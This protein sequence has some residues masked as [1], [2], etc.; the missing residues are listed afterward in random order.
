MESQ[1]VR[2]STERV[3]EPN[4][5][6]S[7]TLQQ[8]QP[9]AAQ[10]VSTRESSMSRTSL[11][12]LLNRLPKPAQELVLT[13]YQGMSVWTYLRTRRDLDALLRANLDDTEGLKARL[14]ELQK[15]L[16]EAD[17]LILEETYAIFGELT[18]ENFSLCDQDAAARRKLDQYDEWRSSGQPGTAPGPSGGQLRNRSAL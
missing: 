3:T 9:S 13:K 14:G 12:E 2:S 15:T 16:S 17:K 18:E 8:H 6:E 5:V 7:G 10:E 4:S 1:W 11:D